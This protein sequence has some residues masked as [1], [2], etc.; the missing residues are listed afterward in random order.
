MSKKENF[1]SMLREDED[2]D[3]FGNK[4]GFFKGVGV[5]SIV[6][7]A[8]VEVEGENAKKLLPL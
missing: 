5:I 2:V 7:R 6:T 1:S 3:D 8:S 4:G